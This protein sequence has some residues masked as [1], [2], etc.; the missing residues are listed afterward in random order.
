MALSDRGL[1]DVNDAINDNNTNTDMITI[2]NDKSSSELRISSE[3][4]FSMYAHGDGDDGSDGCCP[5]VQGSIALCNDD[6]NE[7]AVD[8][9]NNIKTAPTTD[10]NQKIKRIILPNT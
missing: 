5:C 7:N 2:A 6:T 9:F 4:S 1:R 8:N 10:F 3:G